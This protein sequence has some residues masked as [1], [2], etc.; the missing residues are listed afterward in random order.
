MGEKVL[1]MHSKYLHYL[2]FWAINTLTFITALNLNA[3]E[4]S[5]DEIF[6][7]VTLR[8]THLVL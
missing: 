7:P 4:V 2:E 8:V 6:Y 3:P 1:R 5:A